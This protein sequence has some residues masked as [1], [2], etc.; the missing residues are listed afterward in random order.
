[1]RRAPNFWFATGAWWALMVLL[2]AL[3]ALPALASSTILQVSKV[4]IVPAIFLV[5]M[6]F[7]FRNPDRFLY[8][9]LSLGFFFVGPAALVFM[10]P[11]TSLIL[12]MS[13]KLTTTYYVLL[14][15]ALFGLT[16][17]FIVLGVLR[18]IRLKIELADSYVFI[19]NGS[20]YVRLT[21]LQG[22]HTTQGDYKLQFFAPPLMGLMLLGYPLQKYLVLTSGSIA[23][24]FLLAVLSTPIAAWIIAS[25]VCKFSLCVVPIWRYERRHR[26][27]VYLRLPN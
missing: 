27:P 25:I 9:M 1:M 5:A 4:L 18:A 8:Y 14:A 16:V 2:S 13:D 6:G 11:L 19:E 15:T 17:M 3:L 20:A 24:S 26:R 22:P 21:D 10:T 7:F 23:V 12:V